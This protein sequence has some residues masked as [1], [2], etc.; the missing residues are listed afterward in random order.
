MKLKFPRRKY[1]CS[2]EKSV[3]WPIKKTTFPFLKFSWG[4]FIIATLYSHMKSSFLTRES[5]G[6]AIP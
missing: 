1:L 4:N 6:P 3:S 5:I 2:L